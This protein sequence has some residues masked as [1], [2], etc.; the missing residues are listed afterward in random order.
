MIE[1]RVGD[2]VAHLVD[3]DAVGGAAEAPDVIVT[4]DAV[5]F[6]HLLVDRDVDGVA[7]EGDPR[8]SPRSSP[9]FRARSFSARA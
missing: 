1:F 3:G 8:C 4:T 5:G 6:Y 2:E 7:V 9:R